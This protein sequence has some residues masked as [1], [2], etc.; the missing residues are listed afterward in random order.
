MDE[1]RPDPD[2]L[3]AAAAREGRGRL[4]VFLGAAPGVGKTWE[5]LAAAQHAAQ[6]GRDVLIGVVETHGRAGTEAQIGQL[7]VLP[8]RPIAYRGQVLEEFDLDGALH[9]HPGLLLVDELAHDNA[10]GSRHRKRWEDVQALLV[11]GIDVWATLNVQHLESL[12]DAILRITGVRVRE[13][14][15]DRVLEAADAIELIDLPPAELRQRLV[16]GHVYP[17]AQAHRALDQFFREG[18]L[19]ALREMALRRAAE[20]VD[21]DVSGYMRAK[22]ISGPWPAGD[23]VLA[24]VGPDAASEA[25]VRQA[26]RLAEALRAPWIALHLDGSASAGARPAMNMALQLGAEIETAAVGDLVATTLEIAR[27]RNVTHIVMGRGRPLL[28]RRLFGR[29][30]AQAMLRHSLDFTLHLVPA[31]QAAVMRRRRRRYLPAGLWPWVVPPLLV[32]VVAV[33][34]EALQAVVPAEA[35]GMAFLAPVVASA[36]LYGLAV[37]LATGVMAFLAWDFFFLPPV[38]SLTIGSPD[39]LIALVIFMGVAAAT[40]ALASRLRQEMQA[41]QGRIEGL[42]RIGRFSRE[43]GT[44]TTEADLLAV[45]GRQAADIAGSAVVLV[46]TGDG[47]ELVVAAAI[48]PEGGGVPAPDEAGWAAARWAFAKQ[49]ETG[50]GTSTLPSAGWRFLPM[51]TVRGV[52]GVLG[53]Q[54]ADDARLTEP[55]VQALAALADQAAVA[56]ERVRLA[57]DAARTAAQAETHALRTALLNS[58]SHDLRTPLAAIRGAAGTL[59][60][61]WGALDEATRADLLDSIEE[62]VGR[63]TRFLGNIMDMTRLEGGGIVPRKVPVALD[64]VIGA[65]VARVPAGTPVAMDVAEGLPLLQADPAL[66]EQVLFN[67]L[68]NAVKYA[69]AGSLIRVRAMQAGR[70]LVLEVADEGMG[71]PAADLAHVFDSF[72]RARHG[73]RVAPGTGLGLA[74][75]RGLTE[76]MGGTITAQSPRPDS[77]ADAPHGTV[78]ALRFPL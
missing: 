23:R 52:V 39:D 75:A 26:R 20:R 14:L 63:M 45:I 15:P 16:E 71:I 50:Q 18:N 33:A 43:L 58:L 22:A 27:R 51:R 76:A 19:T 55:L 2:A 31:P 24:L 42:R 11:A 64:E 53:L 1:Q 5:M 59:R 12:N 40:G 56:M 44:P 29:T 10:P 62:D 38:L 57:H 69:P 28:W 35:W 73:D 54:A 13:T 3:V 49:E 46:P 21:A 7:P 8:R 4:K 74:I 66:L 37:A 32:A 41:A 67:L 34:G 60:D 30:L 48:G 78:M 17:P 9:R 6:A 77:P 47:G 70:G 25:V 65:A 36:S 61:A 72:Y 68:D